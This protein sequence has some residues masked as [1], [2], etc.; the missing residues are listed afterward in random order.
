MAITLNLDAR[1]RVNLTKLLPNLDIHSVKAYVEG[2][3]IVLEP[4]VTI[5]ARELWLYENPKALQAVKTG[6][7]QAREGKLVDRGSFAQYAREEI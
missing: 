7:Q 2:D 4:L 5:P 1:H 3:R 6:L